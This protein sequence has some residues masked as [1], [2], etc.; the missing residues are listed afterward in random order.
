MV[1]VFIP[2]F[3]KM[4]SQGQHPHSKL[5]VKSDT[6]QAMG[7]YPRGTQAV[8]GDMTTFVKEQFGDGN[9]Y[10]Y[11]Y[12]HSLEEP[13]RDYEARTSR[14][15]VF[16]LHQC[17]E[18]SQ[19]S[20]EST[21][22]QSANQTSQESQFLTKISDIESGISDI[23]TEREASQGVILK[24]QKD[25]QVFCDDA[26]TLGIGNLV[27][28]ALRKFNSLTGRSSKGENHQSS[29]S[30]SLMDYIAKAK[31]QD[32]VK[33]SGNILTFSD[34]ARLKDVKVIDDRYK[35]PHDE[36]G[37]LAMLLERPEYSLAK[38]NYGRIF[39]W[40]VGSTVETLAEAH[41]S[42]V[43]QVRETGSGF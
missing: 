10:L 36:W 43:V 29:S 5:C 28:A 33:I 1:K 20:N 27:V 31:P 6:L 19:S 13:L 39:L 38:E 15:G 35:I 12:P 23:E 11:P 24:L 3:L 34:H 8:V 21:S 18:M 40:V 37:K 7:M 30:R 4:D 2:N 14:F 32:L 16:T 17:E 42:N 25:V 22:E 41:S 26:V 9:Y